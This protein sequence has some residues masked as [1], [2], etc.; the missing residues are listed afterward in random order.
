MFHLALPVPLFPLTYQTP[1]LA[2]LFRL[3]SDSTAKCAGP[4]AANPQ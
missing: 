1:A 2:P 3:P 4:R